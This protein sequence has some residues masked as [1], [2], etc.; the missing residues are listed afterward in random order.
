[1][2]GIGAEHTDSMESFS[3]LDSS[4]MVANW[5]AVMEGLY[6]R[7]MLSFFT[8]GARKVRKATLDSDGLA[9]GDPSAYPTH[10]PGSPH[11]TIV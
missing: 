3:K 7:Q 8:I 6:K 4:Q 11:R 1:M 5:P 9:K 10:L 2:Q